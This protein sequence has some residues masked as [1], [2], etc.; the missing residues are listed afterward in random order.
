MDYT[1]HLTSPLGELLLASDGEAL[2]GLWFAGQRYHARGLSEDHKEH[3]VPV[4]EEAAVWLSDYFAGRIPENAPLLR[5]RRSA[6][7]RE[8]WALLCEIPYGQTVT[9]GDLAKKLALRRGDTRFSAQAVG[10]AVGR[11]PVSLLIPCHR[12]VGACG[13]LTGYAGGLNRKR[14]LLALEAG[15]AEWRRYYTG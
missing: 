14:A 3:P 8:V 11:N 12:V 5:P 10:G 6:F 2:I 9:Y 1:A 7:Q 15:E 4:L 13:A